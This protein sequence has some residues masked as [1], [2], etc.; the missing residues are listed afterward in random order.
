MIILFIL[1]FIYILLNIIQIIISPKRGKLELIMGK[2]G[3][4]K[5]TYMAHIVK[6]YVK[7]NIPVFCNHH[8]LGANVITKEWLGKYMLENCAIIIDEAQLEFDNRNF[9]A[10]TNELKFFFSNFR[11]FKADVYIISQSYEDLDVKIRRQAQKM[12]ILKP[13]IIPFTIFIQEIKMDFGLNEEKTEIVTKFKSS[14]LP[15]IGWKLKINFV[16]WKY[17]DSY[18]KPNLPQ[19]PYIK[20]WGDIKASKNI[21]ERIKE[22]I[23]IV[24]TKL[25]NYNSR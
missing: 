19:P 16:V 17:F 7:K 15:I 5:S 18:S 20:K 11:H 9:K 25:L 21:K 14:I 23:N 24:K 6:K 22:T 1:I 4:G 10:F 8:V 12:Y 2:P 3:S 13:S